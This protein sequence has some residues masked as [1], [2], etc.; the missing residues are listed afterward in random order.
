MKIV[1][2]NLVSALA[3]GA[4]STALAMPAMAQSQ[5]DWTFG[6]G[7]INVNP[8]SDNGS[9][10]GAATTLGDDTQLSLT[11]EYFI[12]D[13][14]G[15]ELLAATPFEHN[16]SLGGTEIGSTKHLPPTVSLVYHVP[17]K[18]KITPFFGVG[19]NYTT[20]FEE[21]TAL[22]DLELDDSFGLAA[23]VGADWQISDRGALRVSVRYMDIKTDATLDGASIGTAK[24]D[25]ISVGASYVHRF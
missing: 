11:G 3:L 24:I 18:G 2:H 7:I 20:F 10:A 12:R 16:I 19:V 17:T 8:K 23:T 14:L 4:L 13:N 9:L 1:T 6:V 15:I 22:G 25:P 5:G 21:T